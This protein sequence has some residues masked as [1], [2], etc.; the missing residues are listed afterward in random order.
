MESSWWLWEE[1]LGS[2]LTLDSFIVEVLLSVIMLPSSSKTVKRKW[3]FFTKTQ[4]MTSPGLRLLS[5]ATRSQPCSHLGCFFGAVP[6]ETLHV[7]PS[8]FSRVTTLSSSLKFSCTKRF[9]TC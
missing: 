9:G 7:L 3:E 5:F 1:R 8:A 4:I 2:F 6:N